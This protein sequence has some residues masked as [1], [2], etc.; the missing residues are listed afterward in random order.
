MK[1]NK[2]SRRNFWANPGYFTAIFLGISISLSFGCGGSS[3]GSGSNV[4][5]P[6]DEENPCEEPLFCD[7]DGTCQ[8]YPEA[9]VTGDAATDGGDDYDGDIHDGGETDS[10]VEQDADTDGGI[11]CGPEE[12]PCGD[13]CCEEG[14]ICHE[15][16]CIL[17]QGECEDDRTCQ[18]DTYCHNGV[19]IP[20]GT[21]PR[22]PFNPECT[23]V[24]IAGLFQPTL[25][26]AWTGPPAD[27]PYPSHMQVL[28]TPLVA[29]FNFND[30]PTIRNP[31]IVFKSYNCSDGSS[32]YPNSNGSCHGVIRVID[33]ATCEQLYNVG[34]G[35]NGCNTPA[36]ADLNGNGRP[37]IISV[38]GF[39]QIRAYTYDPDNDNWVLLMSGHYSDNTP[40]VWANVQP[41]GWAGLAVH[42]LDDDGLPEV[43]SG[44]LVYNSEGLLL[45]NSLGL[46]GRMYSGA[47]YPVAADV[48]GDG[49]VELT[50]GEGVYEFDPD[51]HGWV[52][53]W[54]D[55]PHQG[56][57]AL[58]DFGTY[59]TDPADD[60]RFTLDGIAETI[61]IRSGTA[62]IMTTEGRVIFQHFLPGGGG[63]GP[64]TVGDF[65]GDGLAEFAAAGS[66]SYTVFD[67]DCSGLPDFSLCHSLRT[68]GVLWTQDSQDYS[69]NRT[70]SSLFDFEGDGRTEAIY[71]DEVFTR[72]YDGR[73]GEVVFSTWTSSCTWN[74]NPIVAD[75]DGDF[76]AELVVPSNTNCGTS[77][78]STKTWSAFGGSFYETSHRGNPMDPLF[79]GIR[80][81]TEDDCLSGVCD[82]GYCRCT[83]DDDCGG[84][85]SGFVCD[86][87]PASPMTPTPGSG[88]TCRAEWLGQINGI[89]VHADVLGRWVDSRTIWNQHAYT[90][91][92]I[93]ED[94]TVPAT[95]SWVQNWEQ[96][97]LNNFRMNVQGSADVNTS[98]DMTASMGFVA[99]CMP[100]GAAILSVR[101]CN[102]G[103]APVGSG[104]PATFYEGDPSNGL[105][106]CTAYTTVDLYP[107][108]C[109]EIS[110]EWESAPPAA[111]PK[112]VTIITDDDGTGSGTTNECV[113]E[114][115]RSTIPNV[116]C[117]VIG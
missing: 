4:G 58:G 68:D 103:T 3:G 106:I 111:D 87:P 53:E 75:V 13:I 73:T 32:G 60:D 27:D 97:G 116:Y 26:C 2:E 66:D 57:I 39:G 22:G 45:D 29:D 105:D 92:N 90:V 41:T 28:S 109:E 67:P 81:E 115:N 96:D 89:R 83:D 94:G 9:G 16:D 91:T 20:Y 95:S 51:T 63:G 12:T 100:S 98:P 31:S 50:T 71:A 25:Q 107:G 86:A 30:D 104:L 82:A 43:L 85:G 23:R 47:G 14:E 59:G 56:Y 74:E 101:I 62:R 40:V 15:G 34:S 6:C 72:V 54:T 70:G 18:N 5:D 17:D 11:E 79:R 88:N 114:N 113:E 69:S 48:D 61:S 24:S 77:P 84:A 8:R 76:A 38:S 52:A 46:A 80:C 112:D 99:D 117:D 1:N 78:R 7:E 64:P 36:L 93:E 35:L 55:G 10:T 21:G 65:D 110:C 37:E 44:G 42:D 108:Q 102:R 19:C 49:Y 33:G